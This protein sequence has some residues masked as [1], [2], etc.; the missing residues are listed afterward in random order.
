MLALPVCGAQDLRYQGHQAWST[1]EGLP[2]SSVHAVL[3]T[4]DG[5]VW[6]ATEGGLAR[7]D[8]VGFRVF[9]QS[10]EKAF[11]SDD[12]CCLANDGADGLWV[13]TADGLIHL[14]KGQLQ[15]YGAVDGLPS[16]EIVAIKAGA[17]GMLSV[18]TSGGGARWTGQRFEKT[19][20][21]EDLVGDGRGVVEAE[22]GSRWSFD[23]SGVSVATP[24]GR[25]FWRVG[26]E[27]PAGRV[28]TVYVD[29]EGLAW[30]GMN[31]GL[32]VLDRGA[33]SAEKVNALRTNSVLSIFE[34]AEGD[35]WVG[36]ETSGLHI[37]R[38]LAF[39]GETALA[40]IAVT[41][42]A[43]TTDGAMWV[44][45]RDDGLRRVRDG[46]VDEPVAAGALTSPVILCVTPDQRGGLWV[47]TPDGLNYIDAGLK[48]R[49]MTSGDGLPDDYVRSLATDGDG[50]V[51][52]GTQHGLVH[53]NGR[54]LKTLTSEDGL[55]GDV[56][57]SL[58]LAAGGARGAL[59][60]G[61]SGGLSRVTSDGRIANFTS[62]DGLGGDIVSAMA[63]DEGG[64]L[65]VATKGGGLSLFDGRRFVDTGAFVHDAGIAGMSAD[66]AGYLWLRMDRGIDRIAIAALHDCVT[67]GRCAEGMVAHF[68]LADGLPNAEVVAGGTPTPW[69]ATNGEMWFATRGGV[70]VVDTRHMPVAVGPPPVVLQRLLVDDVAANPGEGE[71]QIPFGHERLTMEY[72][73]LSFHAPSEIRYRFR[74]E[75]FDKGWIDAGMR[76]SASYTN[77]P[78]GAYRF[79]VEAA[80]GDGAWSL[81]PAE[82]SFRIVPPFYRRWWFV[83]SAVLALSACLAGLYLL[84]L[85]FVR[86]RFDAVL[87]ERNRMAR[88]I[89]DTLTQDFV[90]T[91]LQ[92]DII[93]QQLAKGKTELAIEQVKRTRQLVTEGLAEARQSIWELRAN[94]SQD[95]L[96]TRLTR[97][98][99]REMFAAVAPKLRVGGAYRALE[100]RV[101]REVLRVAQEAL[102]NVLHH[103]EATEV[104]IELHYSS[105]TLMLMIED[106]G[107]GFVVDEATRKMGHYGL[108]GMQERAATI[109]GTLEIDSAPGQGTR[110]TLRVPSPNSG[111]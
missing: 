20:V 108:L 100:P 77:L 26:M 36:T 98:V 83:V 101:E 61:T 89:H 13:G 74:L 34:D 111:R 67:K 10:T 84:R 29:R 82:V 49:R 53:V 60:A 19:N 35:H 6:A 62:K 63:R 5:Y 59:W 66:G 102:N 3:Q 46:V 106:N 45:T 25:R 55:G 22:D 97:V 4:S 7:F 109:D 30:V 71:R 94:N 38:R 105:D 78:P 50:T 12:V 14:R 42:V 41:A 17:N 64:D 48:V 87:A 99:Q 70:A 16:A 1:A 86:R 76:R 40:D 27:L 43:Q 65:W 80:V 33:A 32:L 104:Q 96:P 85:R 90:G 15:R 75:E 39:R 68:G 56:I 11:V 92:L 24:G 91:S 54:S 21:G 9:R 72:A 69:M 81:R 79:M 88:E 44:G 52:V 28:Q 73:G 110:I 93:A 37:L 95:S 31:D 8:G 23:R 58:L 2:Q 51:W 18:E 57:G 107:S 47:G 103:A